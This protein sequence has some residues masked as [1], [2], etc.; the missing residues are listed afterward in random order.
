LGSQ[1]K[2]N[3]RTETTFLLKQGRKVTASLEGKNKTCEN[4][5]AD[6]VK[7]AKTANNGKHDEDYKAKRD[8][9]NKA[10][11][12]SREKAKKKT[13]ETVKRVAEL[14]ADNDRM[15][16]RIKLLAKELNFLKQL[17]LAHD[18]S[19]HG[20]DI[21]SQELDNILKEEVGQEPIEMQMEQ[22]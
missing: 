20:G 2:T 21:N 4:L 16:E 6:I 11:R 9:N 22:Y 12:A 8:S 1:S 14:K 5:I 10:V 3:G 18:A 15:E 19:G 13:E 17:F 7:M